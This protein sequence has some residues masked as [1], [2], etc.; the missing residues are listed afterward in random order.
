MFEPFFTTKGARGDG[1]GLSAVYGMVK[2]SG[3]DMTVASAPGEG[4]RVTISFPQA[5]E[6]VGEAALELPAP[7]SVEAESVLLV[8]D[9]DRARALVGRLL[10]E[11][12]YAVHEAGLPEEALR[13]CDDHIVRIDL[14]LSDVVMPQMS[15]PTLARQIVERRPGLPVLFVSGYLEHGDDVDIAASGSEFLQKPFTPHELVQT[16]RRVLDRGR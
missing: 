8:E 10:R 14:L 3:G 6:V 13:L 5:R 4:T 15:G 16:V 2:Q 7:E 11:S 9:D 1:L 12:G